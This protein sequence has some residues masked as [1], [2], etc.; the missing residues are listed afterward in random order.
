MYVLLIRYSLAKM[1][2]GIVNHACFSL[3]DEIRRML[4]IPSRAWRI[5]SGSRWKSLQ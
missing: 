4:Y 3:Q 1:L 5:E 2:P